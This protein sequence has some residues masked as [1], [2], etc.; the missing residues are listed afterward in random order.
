MAEYFMLALSSVLFI[1]LTAAIIFFLAYTGR[2]KSRHSDAV[3]ASLAERDG[4]IKKYI[5]LEEELRNLKIQFNSAN[6]EMSDANAL[7][8]KLNEDNKRLFAELSSL[9]TENNNLKEK[10]ENLKADYE[11]RL[12]NQKKEFL[13]LENRFKEEFENLSSRMLE[14]KSKKFVEINKESIYG[15]L[16]PL[17]EKINEF[18]KRV[19]DT[20]DKESKQRFS[21]Q[22]KIGELVEVENTMKR[23]TDN[24]TAALKGTG[25]VQGD[26]GEMI[27]EKLLEHS[28]LIKGI[29]YETQKT[30]KTTGEMDES[31]KLRP[32][33]IVHLPQNRDLI[34]DS[35]VSLTD[36][37]KYISI[38]GSNNTGINQDAEADIDRF[39]K[40]HVNSVRK[41]ISELSDK[42][43][44]R[45]LGANSLD[46]VIMFIPIE[47]A[48]TAAVNYDRDILT[49]AYSRNVIVATPSIIMLVL[50]IVSSLWV[51]EKSMEN[52]N[53][54]MFIAGQLYDKFCS[55]GKS[56]EEMGAALDKTVLKYGDAKTQL[57][58]GKG[59]LMGK[60]EK[61]KQLGAKSTKS[62]DYIKFDS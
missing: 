59:N 25:K 42:N 44:S 48:Y 34:I 45:L 20:Y 22:T 47:F 21:L 39:L 29:Q 31:I 12:I 18:Q 49:F 26:W 8:E 43:Y 24:L 38:A 54:I 1:G 36:Y 10:I 57:V 3:S 40:S 7:R 35:K 17:S 2:L 13:E 30:L 23:T 28:G 37:E 46:T 50:K 27:L 14:D 15:I 5:V 51:Q 4:I 16:N 9:T 6:I 33:V 41:H 58:S 53:E 32:D 55:F 52:A 11:S 56:M 19:E 62:I 61:I 60:F